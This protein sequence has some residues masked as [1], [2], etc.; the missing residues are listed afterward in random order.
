MFSVIFLCLLKHFYG[1]QC[2]LVIVATPQMI[3]VLCP[4]FVFPDAEER[5]KKELDLLTQT[6]KFGVTEREREKEKNA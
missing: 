2:G 1:F 5:K 4:T 6:T 3:S